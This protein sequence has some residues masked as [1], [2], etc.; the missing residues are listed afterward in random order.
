LR[1]SGLEYWR[2][3]QEAQ[4]SQRNN[5]SAISVFSKPANW[6]RNSLNTAD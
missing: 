2:I 5:A 3:M 6:S 4:L 1:Y